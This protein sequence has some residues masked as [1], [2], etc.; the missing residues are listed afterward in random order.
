M[1]PIRIMSNGNLVYIIPVSAIENEVKSLD[2]IGL[3]WYNIKEEQK[4][5]KVKCKKRKIK[6]RAHTTRFMDKLRRI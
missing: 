3:L 2:E 5:Y 4:E 1:A 6:R